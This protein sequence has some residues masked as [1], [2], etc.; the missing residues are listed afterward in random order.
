M[1]CGW[2][3]RQLYGVQR[4]SKLET[5][6]ATFCR[7]YLLRCAMLSHPRSRIST[8]SFEPSSRLEAIQVLARIR[9]Y[10]G[11]PLEPDERAELKKIVPKL[12]DSVKESDDVG[13]QISGRLNQSSDNSPSRTRKSRGAVDYVTCASNFSGEPVRLSLRYDN[14][15]YC[16]LLYDWLFLSWYPCFCSDVL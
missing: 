14:H 16:H 8:I 10:N 4:P 5:C 15:R 6:L 13:T 1:A 7:A 11:A 12:V 9:G 2:H 3:H